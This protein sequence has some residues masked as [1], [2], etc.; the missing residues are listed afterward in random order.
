MTR[1]ARVFYIGMITTDGYGRA[2]GEKTYAGAAARKMILVVRALRSVGHR[3]FVVSLPFVG[4][5]AARL[6]YGPV[7]TTDGGAPALFLATLRSR[8]LRKLFGP[9]V[10]AGFAGRQVGR[11]DTVI[12]YNHAVEYLPALL[13]LRL[14]GVR[15]VQDIEDA[16]TGEETG[17]RGTLNRLSF[18]ATSALTV[19]RKMV[20][21]D[22]VARELG[23]SLTA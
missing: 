19:R 12:V 18:V 11:Q 20:V 10:L 23:L 8:Y 2:V 7:T 21:A 5:G 13:L 22:H 16:P 9:L 14:K 1:R 3:A 4:T 15:I 6:G 17:L